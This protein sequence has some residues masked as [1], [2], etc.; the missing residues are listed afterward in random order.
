MVRLE[1]AKVR[2]PSSRGRSRRTRGASAVGHPS[3]SWGR[4]RGRKPISSIINDAV[5]TYHEDTSK[6]IRKLMEEWEAD[7]NRQVGIMEID[8]EDW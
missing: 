5:T 7:L 1:T 3:S 4:T 2:S 8:V 6:E